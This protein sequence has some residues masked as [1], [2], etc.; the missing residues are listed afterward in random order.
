[1]ESP[2]ISYSY[3]GGDFFILAR[4]LHVLKRAEQTIT[5]IIQGAMAF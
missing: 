4:G 3:Q 1:M 5:V 2:W